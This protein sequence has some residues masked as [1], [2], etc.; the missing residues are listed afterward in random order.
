VEWDGGW[1]VEM[2]EVQ[3]TFLVDRG[4]EVLKEVVR[5]LVLVLNERLADREV[6]IPIRVNATM[7]LG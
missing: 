1:A 5:Q 6:I 4:L 3:E 2:M 7:R